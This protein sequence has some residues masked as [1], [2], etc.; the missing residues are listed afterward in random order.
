MISRLNALYNS[1]INAEQYTLRPNEKNHLNKK[2][3]TR[4]LG[5]KT[6]IILIIPVIQNIPYGFGI[7]TLCA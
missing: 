1:T 7:L 2:N 5:R 4:L 3:L 6:C